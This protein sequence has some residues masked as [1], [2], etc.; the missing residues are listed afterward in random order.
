MF[1][2]SD[3]VRVTAHAN[4]STRFGE[5]SSNRFGCF[6]FAQDFVSLTSIVESIGFSPS[7]RDEQAGQEYKPRLHDNK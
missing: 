7:G 5:P 6:E 2:A 3:T 1:G 4:Q